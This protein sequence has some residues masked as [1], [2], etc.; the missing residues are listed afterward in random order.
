MNGS[1]FNDWCVQAWLCLRF[2]EFNLVLFGTTMAHSLHS[3]FRDAKKFHG[4]RVGAGREQGGIWVDMGRRDWGRENEW[5]RERER[6]VEN[7]DAALLMCCCSGLWTRGTT[8]KMV[9]INRVRVWKCNFFPN[10]PQKKTKPENYN[11]KSKTA[12]IKVIL[13]LPTLLYKRTDYVDIQF[14]TLLAHF[15]NGLFTRPA[16]VENKLHMLSHNF[17]AINIP[18]Q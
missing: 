7:F 18:T 17:E 13:V 8:Q 15:L 14:V 10:W 5:K 11:D 9:F 16:N 1:F 4:N 3:F 2:V 6:E 12:A